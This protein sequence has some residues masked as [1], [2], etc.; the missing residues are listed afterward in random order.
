MGI[1]SWLVALPFLTALVIL[2]VP[3]SQWR[4]IRW[5]ALVGGTSHLV[6]T[7]IMTILYLRAAS[8]DVESMRT[9]LI[10]KLYLV[11]RVPWFRSLGIQYYVG[12][13]GISV[14]M[15][16]LTSIIIFAGILASWEV[17]VR[18]KEFFVLLLTLVTGVFG[19]FVSFDLFQFFMFY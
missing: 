16:I 3:A 13:D 1:V 4:R 18:P 9:A 11:E 6:L 7:A 10:S 12:V 19:V 14:A 8:A 2:A 17:S 5:I 15:V